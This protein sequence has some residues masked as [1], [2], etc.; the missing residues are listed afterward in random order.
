M[1]LLR[2]RLQETIANSVIQEEGIAPRLRISEAFPPRAALARGR[3]AIGMTAFALAA[4]IALFTVVRAQRSTRADLAVTIALQRRRQPWF[5]KAMQLVS[6]PG[7]PPQSRIIPPVLAGLWFALGFRIEAIF[8]L[9]AWGTGFVSFV[10]KWIMR[11]PRPEHPEIAIAVARIGGTSFPSGHV[12][13]YLGV[14]GFLAFLLETLVRPAALRKASVG[15][16]VTLLATVG[17]S[18]IYLGHHWLTDV[19]ASYLLGTSY[20][21]GLT[22]LYRRV[23]VW[24]Y[25]RRHRFS[26]QTPGMTVE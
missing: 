17:P 2:D 22:A 19:S 26:S 15:A 18:R 20:L 12:L 6:W 16:L 9:L 25:L 1:P 24:Q 7:F 4:F 3:G 21:L 5:R 13:N 14:Y 23:K 8:Q 11:R 10:V